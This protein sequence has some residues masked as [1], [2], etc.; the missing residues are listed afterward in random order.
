[1]KQEI[2]KKLAKKLGA[3]VDPL[4]MS[5]GFPMPVCHFKRAYFSRIFRGEAAYSHCAS[6]DKKYYGFK[7]NLLISSEGG[8]TDITV[9]AANIDERDSL[10][11]LLKGFMA[12]S[13]LIKD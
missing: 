11:E 1:M 13:L 7:G 5:D 6:K 12:W 2:H 10:W 8:I 4:H 3:F 9:A